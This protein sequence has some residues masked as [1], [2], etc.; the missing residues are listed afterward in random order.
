MKARVD[1]ASRWSFPGK[2][3][4]LGECDNHPLPNISMTFKYSPLFSSVILC[5]LCG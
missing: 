2:T 1:F 3:V 5:G 4:R